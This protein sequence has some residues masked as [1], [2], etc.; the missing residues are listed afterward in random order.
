VTRPIV[1]LIG[2]KRAGKDSVA[3]VLTEGFG[4][5]RYAFADPLKASLLATDPCVPLIG[6]RVTVRLSEMVERV[7][8]EAAKEFAEVRRLLQAYGVAVREHVNP[9][10]WLDATMCR[11]MDEERPVVITDVRFPN[12][13]DAIEAAGGVLVRVHRPGLPDDDRHVSETA[14]DDRLCTWHIA[15]EGGL[16]ELRA[17]ATDLAGRV[18]G[19]WS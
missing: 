14:L 18:L 9:S 2:K 5:V 13:A 4:F 12:E 16:P 11:V 3:S 1:G 15:N 19:W 6:S 7:G 10:V 17:A 8:W